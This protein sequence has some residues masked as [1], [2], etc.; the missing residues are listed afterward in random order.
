MVWDGQPNQCSELSQIISLS[1]LR[2]F[3]NLLTV[4]LTFFSYSLLCNSTLL[5]T[6]YVRSSR[7]FS[8]FSISFPVRRKETFLRYTPTNGVK[9]RVEKPTSHHFRDLDQLCLVFFGTSFRSIIIIF[10]SV[11]IENIR[12]VGRRSS[13][14]YRWVKGSFC[15][16]SMW[17]RTICQV[18]SPIN[19]CQE[20]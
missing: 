14:L 20:R 5:C 6:F 1:N 15:S 18:Y 7:L 4:I 19:P 11:V 12:R 17:V 8:P 9:T 13:I 3:I 10:L 2:S 16:V